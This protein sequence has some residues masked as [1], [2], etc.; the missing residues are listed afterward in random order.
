VA[1]SPSSPP[2]PRAEVRDGADGG[3]RRA[4]GS[5]TGAGAVNGT[6]IGIPKGGKNA[7]QAWALVKYLT[8][9]NHAAGPLLRTGSGTSLD[10]QL[11]KSKEL[12]P[13]AN[14]RDLHPESS[15]PDSTDRSDHG[16][17]TRTCP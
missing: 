6:I 1:A 10:A 3:R 11:A 15:Q 13:D 9:D 4:S 17:G 12:K 14:F 2:T 7:D 16:R 8:T 5:S